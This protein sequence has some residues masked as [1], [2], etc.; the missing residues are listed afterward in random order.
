MV[1]DLDY[2]PQAAKP[3][4]GTGSLSSSNTPSSTYATSNPSMNATR[5]ASANLV[6]PETTPQDSRWPSAPNPTAFTDAMLTNPLTP[7]LFVSSPAVFPNPSIPGFEGFD[8]TNWA[9]DTSIFGGLTDEIGK[10]AG[11]AV[12]EGEEFM[13]R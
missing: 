1:F 10:L 4:G 12:F 13:F 9:F 6:G 7:G 8:I 11:D 2:G 5:S 3:V